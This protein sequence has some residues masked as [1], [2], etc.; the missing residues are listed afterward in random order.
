MKADTAKA[1]LFYI[2]EKF[3]LSNFFLSQFSTFKMCITKRNVITIKQI[4]EVILSKL[5]YFVRLLS[6]TNESA[7]RFIWL[8][9]YA[10]DR[11]LK[12]LKLLV[13]EVFCSCGIQE[14]NSVLFKLI[15]CG[16]QFALFKMRAVIEKWWFITKQF[17]FDGKMQIFW[18][19]IKMLSLWISIYSLF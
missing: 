5:K 9:C 10:V 17:K 2:S 18:E 14:K 13:V 12:K 3:P 1:G 4:N 19:L 15:L 16:L 6:L 7:A 11:M 8:Y